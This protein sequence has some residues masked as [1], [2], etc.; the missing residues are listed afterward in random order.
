MTDFTIT[1]DL[2]QSAQPERYCV[3]QADNG[4]L[5]KIRLRDGMHPCILDGMSA[6]LTARK[7]D[8]ALVYLD[9]T[10]ED[11]VF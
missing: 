6:A 9:C 8:G 2:R 11:G 10:R 1:L 5:L 7:P 4:R 3:R